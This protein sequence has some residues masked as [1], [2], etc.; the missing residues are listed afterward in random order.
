MS[1]GIMAPPT[2]YDILSER[3][4]E[5]RAASS[6]AMI[7]QSELNL[8]LKNIEETAIRGYRKMDELQAVSSQPVAELKMKLRDRLARFQQQEQVPT[9]LMDNLG[10]PHGFLNDSKMS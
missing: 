10:D 8:L 5:V 4:A 1:V 9:L 2:D 3:I 7:V 6:T